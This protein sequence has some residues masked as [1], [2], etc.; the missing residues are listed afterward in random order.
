MSILTAHN[1]ESRQKKKG[2]H[3]LPKIFTITFVFYATMKELK[4][5]PT[6][7]DFDP[8]YISFV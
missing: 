5:W 3:I 7:T 4:E 1:V 8:K 2:F 6:K